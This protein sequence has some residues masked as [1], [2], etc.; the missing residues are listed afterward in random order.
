MS[1]L[2]KM[3]WETIAAI[4]G[5]VLALGGAFWRW[6]GRPVVRTVKA[7]YKS[8]QEVPVLTEK[9][10]GL[11][12]ALGEIRS[13]FRTNG[14]SSMRDMMERMERNQD[15]MGQIVKGI[16]MSQA[17]GSF[18]MNINGEI[19]DPGRMLCKLL[20]RT[21]GELRGNNWLTYV[22]EDDR[23]DVRD[24]WFQ[25]VKDQRE[26]EKGFRFK[27]GN[28]NVVHLQIRCYPMLNDKRQ[29][30]GFFGTLTPVEAKG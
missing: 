19:T 27:G 6:I 2:T 21:E 25:A 30:F 22:S 15:N 14:G 10:D 13:E 9:L 4:V 1:D 23:D 3:N 8:L 18:S 24:E 16:L 26:F 28:G 5:T 12:K 11:T 29:L 20:G 17:F 7:N